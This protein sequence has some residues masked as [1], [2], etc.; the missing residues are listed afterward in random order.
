MYTEKIKNADGTFE[1][2]VKGLDAYSLTDTLECGQLF[3]HVPVPSADGGTDYLIPIGNALV[4]V[5]QRRL[6]ELV[7]RNISDFDFEEVAVP[8]FSLRTDFSAIADLLAASCASEWFRAAVGSAKGVAILKQDAWE[9]L[10]SFIVSQ[11]NNIPRIK[12]ILRRLRVEYGENLALKSRR[13]SCPLSSECGTPCEEKCKNCGACYSFPTA[14]AVNAAPE[15]LLTA[16]P[17]FRFRY[18]CDAARRVCSGETDLAKIEAAHSCA[19]SI[20]ELKKIV[21]VGDKVASCTALF[22]LG[23][24]EAFPVDVWMKRAI[25]KYFGGTLDPSVFGEYA[26]VAQQYIFHYIR[27][28]ESAD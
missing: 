19:H 21:G 4:T 23:N 6:G 12:K 7:F 1:I 22:G 10:F 24:L 14:A 16:N 15:K 26:G 5:G 8:F 3:S 25:D 17:G 13:S 20:E 11:N 2:T 18:L 28:I 27:N 9:A